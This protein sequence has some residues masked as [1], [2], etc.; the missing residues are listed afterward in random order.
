MAEFKEIKTENLIRE[1]AAEFLQRESNGTSLITVTRVTLA[2]R[3]T[4]AIIMITVL[5]VEMQDDALQFVRRKR[6]E[7]KE[8]FKSRARIGRIPLFDFALDIGEK[9]RQRLDEISNELE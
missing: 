9:N 6:Q 2:N 7:F 1:L 8:Y 5:P 3:M 4:K